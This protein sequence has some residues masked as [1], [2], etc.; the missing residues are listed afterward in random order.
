MAAQ[1]GTGEYSHLPGWH[2]HLPG[3]PVVRT[4]D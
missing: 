2:G 1:T 4:L 3:W